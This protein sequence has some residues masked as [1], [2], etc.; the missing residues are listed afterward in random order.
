VSQA[1]VKEMARLA[2][3]HGVTFVVAG[4]EDSESM[5]EFAEAN[6]ISNVDISLDLSLPGYTNMPYD[7]HPSAK[8]NLKYAD[9]LEKFLRELDDDSAEAVS[10]STSSVRT[11]HQA[12]LW[13]QLVD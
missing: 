10:R 7:A 12:H 6:G 2:A 3:T 9:K 8:A 1:L 13:R 5:L 4:F 11:P